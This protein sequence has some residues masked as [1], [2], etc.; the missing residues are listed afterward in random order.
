MFSKLLKSTFNSLN[1]LKA[2]YNF[3][4]TIRL[5]FIL[6]IP[7]IF[8]IFYC[9]EFIEIYFLIL[10]WFLVIIIEL[11]TSNNLGAIWHN[12]MSTLAIRTNAI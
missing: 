4:K 1:G 5:E 7:I 2:A 9:F 11:I 12:N 6:T 10:L 8:I 3:D